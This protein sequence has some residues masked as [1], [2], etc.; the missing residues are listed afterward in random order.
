M[1]LEGVVKIEE[2]LHLVVGYGTV[3]DG[4]LAGV[5]HD[6]RQLDGGVRSGRAPALLCLL[7]ALHEVFESNLLKDEVLQLL[8]FC[9]DSLYSLRLK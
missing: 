5:D 4:L 1:D 7:V 9:L 3:D 6:E 2:V 8:G